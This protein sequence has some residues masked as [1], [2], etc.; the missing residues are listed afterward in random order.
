MKWRCDHRSCDCDFKLSPKNVFGA[1]TGCVSD[2][3]L[4]QLSYEDP[5]VGSRPIYWV[6]RTR[7]RNETYQIAI[8]TAMITSSLH[9]Y[10]RSSHNTDMTLNCIDLSLQ[11][12]PW[13]LNK[14]VGL[15][16]RLPYVSSGSEYPSIGLKSKKAIFCLAS[17]YDL[18]ALLV[19][20]H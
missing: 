10:V 7:E 13:I 6:N 17:P 15:R 4:H 19:D 2:A 12:C 5:Y 3:V 9:L 11:L 18:S 8:T 1:S 20:E 16:L 14:A